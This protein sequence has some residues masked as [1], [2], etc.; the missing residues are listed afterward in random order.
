[1]RS[2]S[3][4]DDALPGSASFNCDLRARS[5]P[6]LGT[7]GGAAYAERKLT[8]VD[9]A[10]KSFPIDQLRLALVILPARAISFKT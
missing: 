5:R 1:M 3:Q 9:D 2:F 6:Y 8:S 7:Q 10:I 4:R